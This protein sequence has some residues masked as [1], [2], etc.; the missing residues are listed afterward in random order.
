MRDEL[1]DALNLYHKLTFGQMH[2]RQP[3]IVALAQKLGRG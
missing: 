1:V 3:A 2:R